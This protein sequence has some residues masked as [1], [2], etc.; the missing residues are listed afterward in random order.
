MKRAFGRK[1]GTTCYLWGM[2]I[3]LNRKFYKTATLLTLLFVTV[4]G[5]VL[6]MLKPETEMNVFALMLC[7]Y[8]EGAKIVP[9]KHG[10]HLWRAALIF[11]IKL[12]SRFH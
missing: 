11:G 3:K 7:L 6:A 5:V 2:R 9:A 12:V 10:E 4:M 1:K 8:A